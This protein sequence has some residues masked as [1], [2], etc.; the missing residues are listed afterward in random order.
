[1]LLLNDYD[2]SELIRQSPTSVIFRIERKSDRVAFVAKLARAEYPTSVELC[3]LRHEHTLL[4]SLVLAS[5]VRAEALV[6]CGNGL[7]LILEDVGDR[8]LRTLIDAGPRALTTSLQIALRLVDA[9]EAVHQQRVVHKDLKPDHFMLRD[10]DRGVVLIDLGIATRLSLGSP[11]S[12]DSFEGTLAY[13]SPEQTGRM[14]RAVDRRSDLYSLGVVLYELLTGVRP[15]VASDPL[16]LVHCHLVRTPRPPHEVVPELPRV[17]SRI[18]MKLLAKATEDRYQDAGGLRLDLETCLAALDPSGGSPDFALGRAD[19]S[20]ELRLSQALYGRET[21]LAV[22]SASLE[23]VRKGAV[24][25]CLVR[26]ASGTGK[27]ALVHELNRVLGRGGRLIASKFDQLNRSVPYAPIVHGC[28]TLVRGVLAQS[29]ERLA[30][31]QQQLAEALGPNGGLLVDLIPELQAVVGPQHSAPEVGPAEAQRRFESTFERFLQVFAS[32]E[33]PLVFFLDDLQWADPASLRLIHLILTKTGAGYLLL[34]GAYRDNEVGPLHPLSLALAQLRAAGVTLGETE[35]AALD[36]ATLGQFLADTLHANASAIERLAEITLHKTH[37]NPF[38]VSQFLAALHRQGLLY[39]DRSARAWCWDADAIAGSMMTDNVVDFIVSRYLELSP[40]AQRLLERAACLGHEFDRDALFVIAE[41]PPDQVAADLW[42]ALTFG[43]I[44]P[45][46]GNYRFSVTDDDGAAAAG[47]NA[48]YRFLHDRVQQAAYSLITEADKQALHL[49]IGRRWLATCAGEPNGEDLF[50]VVDHLNLGAP[51]ITDPLERRQLA[52]LDLRAGRRAQAAA[53]HVVA[54][55]LFGHCL[56]LLGDAP[57]ATDYALAFPA[58]LARAESQF[59]DGQIEEAFAQIALLDGQART[60]LD[61][62][63]SRSHRIFMLTSMN[64]LAEA[65][66]CGVESLAL[67]GVVLPVEPACLGPAIGAELEAVTTAL[68]GRQPAELIALP[69]LGAGEQFVVVELLYKIMLASF[70]ANQALMALAVLRAV[71]LMLRH[72][73]APAAPQF[74]CV[75]GL[76]HGEATGDRLTGFRFAELGIALSERLEEQLGCGASSATR[77]AFAAFFSHWRQPIGQA[78]L[79]FERGLK[80][81][82]ESGD[83]SNAGLSA[84]MSLLYR[85]YRGENLDELGAHALA[86]DAMFARKESPLVALYA[87]LVLW[88]IAEARGS[89]DGEQAIGGG[90]LDNREL[91]RQMAANQTALGTHHVVRAASLYRAGDYRRSLAAA[92]EAARLLPYFASQ[93]TAVEQVFYRALA[94]AGVLRAAESEQGDASALLETLHGDEAV[95]RGWAAD[96]PYNHGHRHALVAAEL[97]AARGELDTALDLYECAITKATAHGFVHHQALANELCGV[98][99]LRRGRAKL[100]RSYLVEAYEV[101]RHWGGKAVAD[102]LARRHPMIVETRA[103][104]VLTRRTVSNADGESVT[105]GFDLLA[106]IRATQ[107]MAGELDLDRLIERTLR[108][109]LANAGA[110]R[111]FLV[112]SREGGLEIVALATVQPD[113]VDVGLSEAVDASDR[114]AAGVVQYVA[115]S[116]ETVVL[117]DARAS[118]RFALDPYVLSAQ[119]RSLACLPLQHQGRMTGVLYLENNAATHAFNPARVDL[120]QFLAVQA[121]VAMENAK[122]YGQLRAASL[123]LRRANETLEHKVDERTRE[124][125]RRNRALRVVLDNVGQGLLTVDLEGHLLEERSAMVDRWFGPCQGALLFGDYVSAGDRVFS[126]S[127][128]LGLEAL[129]EGMLPRELCLDQLPR[130]LAAGIRRFQC[131]YLPIAAL[132][133]GT[134]L[135]GLLVVIDDVTEQLLHAREEAAQRERLAVYTALMADREG[136]FMFFDEGCRIIGELSKGQQGLPQLK[137]SLHTLKGNAAMQGLD[138]FAGL[139][140]RAEDEI[141]GQTEPE[142]GERDGPRPSTLDE[143]RA[144]WSEIERTLTAVIGKRDRRG[145]EISSDELQALIRRVRQGESAEQTLVELERWGFEPIERPLGRLAAHARA[146]AQRLGKGDVAVELD[147]G[148]IRLDPERWSP[149]W[150]VLVHVVRNAVDHGFETPEDRRAAG[151]GVPARL[152]LVAYH[153][154]GNL[155]IEIED[156]GRG[157]DWALVRHLAVERGLSSATAADLTQALLARDFSTRREVTESSGRGVG[158]SA[159]DVVVRQLGGCVAVDS[160]S[161][162]GCRWRFTFPVDGSVAILAK[163]NGEVERLASAALAS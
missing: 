146:L 128:Q 152:R 162:K 131:S 57:F 11:P 8:S 118:D 13:V 99:H 153:R 36:R 107:A 34:I 24:E 26:G 71:Q 160:E 66:D 28:R 76:I 96:C 73:N 3:R 69:T 148:G 44:V 20:D 70:S 17:L 18:V 109:L 108:L 68:A 117:A 157:I 23:R 43:L 79:H 29:P 74:Y 138:L 140:H 105:G 53:A 159:V 77:F 81:G 65:I 63:S 61:R 46:D 51:Q 55:G 27:S 130:R 145:L 84:A 106:A 56:A 30:A 132:G 87:A 114:I 10:G 83:L 103:E 60:P 1:V 4:C 15:F 136:F 161:G 121:A 5:V 12:A 112:L 16:E 31:W 126:Q 72:G 95:L 85:F 49:R 50:G 125:A 59:L 93:L 156:T 33:H 14:N 98:F 41:S 6:K 101:Y 155:V 64:R 91:G 67:L 127:W 2:C 139:C 144:R 80:A 39:L 7:A 110:Q 122:L 115:R 32:A 90:L 19:L 142:A 154:C 163:S 35:V 52:Q 62:V 97:A 88:A 147:A 129:R 48:S 104:N 141:L 21:Q 111:G 92:D 113:R 137:R 158:L 25:L 37:G 94:I 40:R 123:D 143:L 89:P 116:G 42:E 119:P 102:A 133:Q 100:A 86:V 120:L 54:A 150:S 124:L 9:V 151:K 58:Q 45:L 135:N 38:F 149:F 134:E 47:V 78:L 82:L 75:L 22:L